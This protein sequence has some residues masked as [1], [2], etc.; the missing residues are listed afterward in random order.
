MHVSGADDILHDVTEGFVYRDIT[1]SDA[2]WQP[3]VKH[4]A[5]LAEYMFLIDDTCR[6]G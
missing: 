3:A 6:V 5:D 4:L 1:V 2:S